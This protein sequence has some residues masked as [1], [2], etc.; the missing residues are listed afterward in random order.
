MINQQM[1]RIDERL[2]TLDKNQKETMEQIEVMGDKI[3]RVI[4]D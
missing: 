1:K 4:G 3:D 2:E